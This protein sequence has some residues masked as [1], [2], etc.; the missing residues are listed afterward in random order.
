[1]ADFMAGG[2]DD[3]G[4]Y[5]ADQAHRPGDNA[6]E[7]RWLAA[8]GR[9]GESRASVEGGSVEDGSAA[10]GSAQ[11]GSA[12]D[13]GSAEGDRA[14]DGASA[15]DDSAEDGASAEGDRAEDGGSAEG[16]RAEGGGSAQ[17]DRAGDD[18]AAGGSA[19][20]GRR[21]ERL[22]DFAQDRC[23]DA[24]RPNAWHVMILNDLTG[25]DDRC[26][27][28]TDNEA[29]G[30]MGRWKAAESW[31]TARMLGVVR[32]MIRRRAVPEKGMAQAGLP[33]QWEPELE[34]E[35]AAQLRTSL[36]AARKL[37][38]LAWSLGARLPQVGDALADGRLDPGQARLIVTETDALPDDRAA[39]A[40]ELILAGL[41]TVNTWAD[42]LR[43]VQR[44]VCTVDP[45]GARRRR[46]E[47][48]RQ[49]ARVRLWRE[50]SGAC[51]L[52]GHALPTDEALAA[53]GHV[54]A[55]AQHYR[56][57]GIRE[58]IDLLRVMAYLD[59]LNG[60]PAEERVA[61]WTAEATARAGTAKA[62]TDAGEAAETAPGRA[63]PAPQGTG[64]RSG[65]PGGRA[66]R[67]DSP[68]GGT[69]DTGNRDDIEADGR[70]GADDTTDDP[71]NTRP[72]GGLAGGACPG[73][74]GPRDHAG[75]ELRARVNLTIP[76]GTATGDDDRP[77]E[78]WE[79]GALDPA[80]ARE[81]LAAA[82]RSPGSEF[83]VTVTDEH[84][85][86]VG[87]GCCQPTR[88]AKPGKHG[89]QPAGPAPPGPAAHARA[90]FTRREGPGPPGGFGSWKLTLPG[91]GT[92]F[93]VDLRAVPTH[94]C[95][96][97]YESAGHDPSHWLRHVVQVR[98][99][100]CS[101]PSCGRHARESDFEH[102]VPHA[103][104]GK[105]CACNCHACSR[106]CHQV[107]QRPGWS[108]TSPTPGWHQWT[109]PSGRTYVQGPW[110]YPA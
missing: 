82:A 49:S 21:D 32:E 17:D 63:R 105:T 29:L 3:V 104:G 8:A 60:T 19:E 2:P 67:N 78:A 14:E 97:A 66:S 22:A 101:F 6:G 12:E 98:D 1:M 103:N 79:L 64:N 92:T 42:L 56:Q 107:K 77:G 46:E 57:Q 34:H 87:H 16:D 109:T 93:T 41:G 72:G 86:A 94:A 13:G 89:R 84:G 28:A 71:G 47:A 55:R 15:Q 96:H 33:W 45:D 48:E 76:M 35:V 30:L 36:V 61:R 43:L 18:S 100:K 106:T 95:D 26:P 5:L 51:A 11:D 110:Q 53:W 80:L 9:P 90:R 75:P 59:L 54:E 44:A 99:V 85:H 102:S 65:T 52:A 58:Y 39:K 25:P 40:E 70:V 27:D 73:D 24:A 20:G 74:T 50:S 108:V 37:L 83:C 4:A 88:P 23:G 62:A 68:G 31:A 10:G 91:P 69:P 38:H 7:E 81:L